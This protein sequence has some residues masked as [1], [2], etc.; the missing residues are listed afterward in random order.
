MH[1]IERLPGENCW[2]FILL[3]AL[4]QEARALQLFSWKLAER[5]MLSSVK[6]WCTVPA[7]VNRTNR[8][9]LAVLLGS[10]ARCFPAL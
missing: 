1:V 5:T 2:A 7:R 8:P 6:G 10:P 4:G 3:P 9:D